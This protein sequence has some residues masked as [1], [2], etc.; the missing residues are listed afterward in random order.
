MIW[1]S[2]MGY[3]LNCE[4]A[5]YVLEVPKLSYA[6]AKKHL[7]RS[8]YCFTKIWSQIYIFSFFN[9]FSS[10]NIQFEG[11]HTRVSNS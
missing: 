5:K 8:G 1:M 4:K 2:D 6:R 9:V 10:K 7:M 11:C 3:L